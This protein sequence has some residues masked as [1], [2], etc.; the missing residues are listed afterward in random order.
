VSWSYM[1]V[2]QH[3]SF[4]SFLLPLVSSNCPTLRNMFCTYL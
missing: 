3:Y 1:G 2:F 4:S